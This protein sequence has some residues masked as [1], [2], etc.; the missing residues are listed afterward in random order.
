M[1][2]IAYISENVLSLPLELTT[3]SFQCGKLHVDTCDFSLCVSMIIVDCER[4][5]S[6]VGTEWNGHKSL[7]NL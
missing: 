3:F 4:R 7:E 6:G 1:E 2:D 5:E